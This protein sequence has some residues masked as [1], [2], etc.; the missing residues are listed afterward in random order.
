MINDPNFH[1]HG[2]RT[3]S[4]AGDP[5]KYTTAAPV[6]CFPETTIDSGN[7]F[8]IS[9]P[10]KFY[11]Q[12]RAS[13]LITYRCFKN[14]GEVERN[15]RTDFQCFV[16]RPSQLDYVGNGATRWRRGICLDL[17]S[18]AIRSA[19]SIAPKSFSWHKLVLELI[20]N[21]VLPVNIVQFVTILF[22]A[23]PIVNLLS[24]LANL[25]RNEPI[26]CLH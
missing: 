3:H 22:M 14:R 5:R 18:C 6:S 2:H 16:W 23:A 13:H 11:S 4:S 17:R 21:L 15:S 7:L 12:H 26:N 19:I 24:Q 1:R 20:K 25:F 10:F 8:I 9:Y